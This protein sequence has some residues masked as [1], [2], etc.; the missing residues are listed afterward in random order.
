MNEEQAE[1]INELCKI[2]HNAEFDQ[3][4]DTAALE[5]L[6]SILGV[7]PLGVVP[8]NLH[9]S[10]NSFRP[11]SHQERYSFIMTAI[12]TLLNSPSKNPRLNDMFRECIASVAP[13][14]DADGRAVL[15]NGKLNFGPY[16]NEPLEPLIFLNNFN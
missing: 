1:I 8:H 11:L 4:I 10:I 16:K 6:L 13:V 9:D 3:Q 7:A 2:Y 5:L 14:T 12:S 15:E